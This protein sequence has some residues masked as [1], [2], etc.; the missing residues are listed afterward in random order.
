MRAVLPVYLD[1]E[2]DGAAAVE[3]ERHLATCA[4]CGEIV[5]H[6]RAFRA[7][8]RDPALRFTAPAE[9]RERIGAA[10]D[11][12]LAVSRAPASR[13]REWLAAAASLLLGIAI[14]AFVTRLAQ[15]PDAGRAI[16]D[17]A[18]A[19]HLRALAG[20]HL[21]DVT[22]TDR[23][24]VKPWFAGRLDFSP[25]VADP[26]AEGFPL[27]GGRVDNL[28]GRLVAALVY[29]HRLHVITVFTWPAGATGDSPPAASETNGYHL[30]LWRRGG[31]SWLAVSDLD[32]NELGRFVEL[33]EGA[34]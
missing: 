8:F 19:A 4:A 33:L 29:H 5:R 16:G 17:E 13:G 10:V 1:G 27:A 6:E 22:S 30:V 7:G 34:R 11:E 26:A 32:R 2:L 12:R 31:M 9:L 28:G 24:T 18:L 20:G 3:V 14:G 25:T 15:A 23:H 21:T